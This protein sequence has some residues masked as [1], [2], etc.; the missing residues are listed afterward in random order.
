M[1]NLP[2]SSSDRGSSSFDRLD[3]RIQRWI[4]QAGWTELRDAQERA[5]PFIL[6]G[7]KDVLI[8][9]STASGKTEAAFFPILTNL[10]GDD[11]RD[12]L[13]IYVS[14]L[15]A[16]INDQWQRLEALAETLEVPVT[17]WH[18]DISSS[19]KTKFLNSPRGCLLI[20][21]E[22]M[23]AML[24]LRGSGLGALLS[25]LRY[26]VVDELH[27]YMGSERGKQ[28]QSQL[29]RIEECLGRRVCRIGLSATL[30]DMEGARTYLRPEDPSSVE[31]IVSG[32]GGQELQVLVKGVVEMAAAPRLQSIGHGD[33]NQENEEDPGLVAKSAIVADLYRVLR[34]SNNLVFPNSRTAVEYFADRL[35]RRC[36]QEQVPNEFWPH[37]GNLSKEIREETEAALKQRERPATAICTSTLELGIDIGAVRSVAQ[38]G[39]PPSVASLR[40]RLGRSG[41]R[42][43]EPA[44]L[45]GYAIERQLTSKSP[46]SDQLREGL[47]QMTAMI[48]LLVKGWYEPIR[49]DGLHASTLVQQT[50]STVSQ[51]GGLHPRD[52]WRI[53]CEHGP[54]AAVGSESFL[55][56]LKELGRNE[57]IFQD[58]TGLILLAP[59]G[60]R[61]CENYQFYA[62]FSSEEEYRIMSSGRVLGSMPIS[63]PLVPGG[64]IIFGGRRWYVVSISKEDLVIEV[65]PGSAGALPGFDG[66]TGASIHDIVRAE[67]RE[68][69]RSTSPIPFLDKAGSGLLLEGRD[70]YRKNNLDIVRIRQAGNETQVLTWRGDWV[71]D[72]LLLMLQSRGFTGQN[73]GLVISLHNTGVDDVKAGLNDIIGETGIGALQLANTVKTKEREKWD[74]LLPTELLDASFASSNLDVPGARSAIESVLSDPESPSRD[75][76][77]EATGQA[78]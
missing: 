39:P 13:A 63:R 32:D 30:G 49:D 18:G 44:I 67:M 6:D 61:I 34:G 76:A 55:S 25:S 50:L 68:V 70:A 66:A 74:S 15:K 19:R 24:M 43:G 65:K 12:G 22:S 28:L 45:R 11:E 48:R 75:H 41:R 3:P 42:R 2:S 60:E 69:L 17:P 37:H 58:G 27:A 31:L 51:Y 72:T 7:K 71:N 78:G 47:V 20:T 56:L 54:F 77:D 33:E 36:E 21:P 62:A 64:S 16:L 23:E 57:V 4:W 38:I 29:H 46:L 35:R 59:I 52:L 73:E 5:I 1:T 10:I 14:P 8:A 53:L 26:V 9:A 40:Q